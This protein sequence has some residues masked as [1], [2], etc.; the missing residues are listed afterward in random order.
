MYVLIV[1]ILG[2]IS[3]VLYGINL[4]W[5]PINE[6]PPSDPADPNLPV[7]RPLLAICGSAGASAA[8]HL[9]A[10]SELCVDCQQCRSPLA[11]DLAVTVKE[12]AQAGRAGHTPSSLLQCWRTWHPVS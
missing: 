11:D 3:T 7:V 10:A 6:E 1:E 4:L 2:A 9:Q 5:D 12:C 8:R